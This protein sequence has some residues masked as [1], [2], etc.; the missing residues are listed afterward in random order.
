[1]PA[2]APL[3]PDQFLP[4]LKRISINKKGSTFFI[5]GDI[6]NG[7]PAFGFQSVG[8]PQ[9]AAIGLQSARTH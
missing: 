9:A 3:N 6:G 1:M 2:V 8:L 5:D 7:L 4:D